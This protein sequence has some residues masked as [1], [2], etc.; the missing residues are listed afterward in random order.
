VENPKNGVT[1]ESL[2]ES[3][4]LQGSTTSGFPLV[5]GPAAHALLRGISRE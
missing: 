5:V 1:K 2:P 3:A 4:L